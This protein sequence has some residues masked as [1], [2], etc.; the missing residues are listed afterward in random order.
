MGEHQ[1]QPQLLQGEGP[2]PQAKT[3]PRRG[4]LVTG[5]GALQCGRVLLGE[6]V[7]QRAGVARRGQERA[8]KRALDHRPAGF[9]SAERPQLLAQC[10]SLGVSYSGDLTCG[11][12]THLVCKELLGAVNTAKFCKA[13]EWGV[14]VGAWRGARRW[15]R[16]QPWRQALSAHVPSS[17]P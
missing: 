15:L 5:T 9:R 2:A 16:V 1:Q 17:P 8:C 14:Q 12:T 13:M 10:A 3:G 4:V 11:L 7:A 6:Q